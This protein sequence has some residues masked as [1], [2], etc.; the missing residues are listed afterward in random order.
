MVVFVSGGGRINADK[1]REVSFKCGANTRIL[2]EDGFL[3][4]NSIDFCTTDFHSIYDENGNRVN[5]D[6]D[7][8]VENNCWIGRKVYI[9][10]GVHLPYGS[11]V[12]ANAVV[13]KPFLDN[14]TMIAGNPAVIKKRNVYWKN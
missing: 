12:G 6:K 8:I 10:K 7:I 14:N 1:G 4:S 11:I 2:L 3:L 9:G 13:T 5:S